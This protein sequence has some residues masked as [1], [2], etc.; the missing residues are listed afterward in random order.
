MTGNIKPEIHSLPWYVESSFSNDKADG[1]EYVGR[2][3]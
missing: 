3:E 1:E 2:Q